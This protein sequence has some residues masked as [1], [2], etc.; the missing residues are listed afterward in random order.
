MAQAEAT[1]VDGPRDWGGL[2][3]MMRRIETGQEGRRH[4]FINTRDM[5]ACEGAVGLPRIGEPWS[6]QYRSLV[7]RSIEFGIIGGEP[8]GTTDFK[9]Y[10]WA[11]V[12]YSTF[13]VGSTLPPATVGFAYSQIQAS[14]STVTRKIDARKNAPGSWSF[15]PV[16]AFV[17]SEGFIDGQDVQINNGSGV[18]VG[19]GET[20]LIVSKFVDPDQV[21][22]PLIQRMNGLM[23]DQVVNLDVVNAPPLPGFT[24][25]LRFEPGELRFIAWAYTFDRGV[26]R[27][28][29]QMAMA[30]NH[31]HFWGVE[32]RDGRPI[33]GRPNY[34][35]F[36]YR[37][38][39]FTGLW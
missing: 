5:D 38:E 19:R 22:M 25:R 11:D 3:P 34:F 8:D 12:H 26:G 35:N 15:A 36:L 18:S 27:I 4:F 28:D 21:P 29:Q 6:N 16:P 31:L 37:A 30:P 10:C 32:D 33:D 23:Y 2:P 13:G 17:T 14:V 9:G 39:N 20:S 24:T 7:A 1:M